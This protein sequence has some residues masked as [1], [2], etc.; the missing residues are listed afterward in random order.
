MTT[1]ISTNTISIDSSPIHDCRLL[2]R[3]LPV[4]SRPSLSSC[5]LQRVHLYEL[6]SHP[7]A[8]CPKAAQQACPLGLG[9]CCP[10]RCYL[11]GTFRVCA[12]KEALAE[13]TSVTL[14]QS[15]DEMAFK[16]ESCRLLWGLIDGTDK[17]GVY[18]LILSRKLQFI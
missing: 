4:R 5:R 13:S 8:V 10:D 7:R 3:L 2:S 16:L 1:R 9:G 17:H 6:F 12:W 18:W 11:R 14:I 15:I